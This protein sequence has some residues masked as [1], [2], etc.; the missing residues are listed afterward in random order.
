MIFEAFWLDIGVMEVWRLDATD[1][2]SDATAVVSALASVDLNHQEFLESGK[3][4][5]REGRRG[6][7][8]VL[9]R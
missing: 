6:R 8:F 2:I 7:L 5:E 3:D 4:Y 1:A 9:G